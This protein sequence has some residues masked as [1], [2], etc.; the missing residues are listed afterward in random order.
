MQGEKI[1]EVAAHQPG[2]STGSFDP[3]EW[4][5]WG[6]GVVVT[7]LSGIVVTF[8]KIIENRNARDIKALTEQCERLQKELDEVH[9]QLTILMVTNARLESE[10]AAALQSAAEHKLLV[11]QYQREHGS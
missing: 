1:V 5:A 7:A 6:V 3:W 4:G 8:W 10:K 11:Q 2:M 9:R